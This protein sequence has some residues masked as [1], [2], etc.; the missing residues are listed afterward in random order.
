MPTASAPSCGTQ[1]TRQLPKPAAWGLYVQHT[2]M[3]AVCWRE[4][5]PTLYGPVSTR[6]RQK[7]NVYFRS[8]LRSCCAPCPRPAAGRRAAATSTA[9][10]ARFSCRRLGN[11]RL[12]AICGGGIGGVGGWYICGWVGG[13]WK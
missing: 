10:T 5:V 6:S 3:R 11:T 7:V 12:E 2:R 4:T 1:P 8:P 13:R 9:I